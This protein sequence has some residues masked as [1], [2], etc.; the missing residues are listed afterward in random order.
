MR[1]PIFLLIAL[2]TSIALSSCQSPKTAAQFYQTHKRQKGVQNFK[3]PGW[4]IWTG[5]G[6]GKAFVKEPEAKAALQLAK[7][8]G[9]VRMMMTEETS[10]ISAKEVSAFLG[11][12]KSD[13]Y[14]DLLQVRS[15]GT[16]VSIL[17]LEKKE[18]LRNMLILV[19][20]EDSFF[21][22]DL[23]TRLRYKDLSKM[24]NKI[25]EIEFDDEKTEEPEVPIVVEPRA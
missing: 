14:E 9:K 1:L 13:G 24:I 4:L 17:V 15:E 8:I 22:F 5:A 18:K 7:R 10:P 6:I 11:H 19:N 21:Y 3:I 20:E 23:K 25:M 12:I 16:T 2:C